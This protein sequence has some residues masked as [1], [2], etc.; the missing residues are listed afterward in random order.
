MNQPP[1]LNN[2]D[3][4]RQEGILPSW[5]TLATAQET[6]I[7]ALTGPEMQALLA[8]HK[9]VGPIDVGLPTARILIF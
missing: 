2:V 5:I 3:T 6:A 4:L 7:N 8:I 9:K 1:Q